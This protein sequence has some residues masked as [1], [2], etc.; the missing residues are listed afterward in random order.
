[1]EGAEAMEGATSPPLPPK[2][3]DRMQQDCLS[4][5]GV[6]GEAVSGAASNQNQSRQVLPDD[7]SNTTPAEACAPLLQ[8][9]EG[10]RDHTYLPLLPDEGSSLPPARMPHQRLSSAFGRH[11]FVIPESPMYASPP[12][13]VYSN[14]SRLTQ[15][16]ADKQRTMSEDDSAIDVDT[17]QDSSLESIVKEH[18]PY[19]SA[20]NP[21]YP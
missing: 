8:G 1:M 17:S 20:E 5:S 12:A 7:D 3:A 10:Y 21:A 4:G 14:V 13:P 11:S 2:V 15:K 6:E 16:T 9:G 18:P 19:T